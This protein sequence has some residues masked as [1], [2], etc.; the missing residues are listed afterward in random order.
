MKHTLWPSLY[1]HLWL[2]AV[3]GCVAHKPVRVVV[4]LQVQEA[5]EFVLAVADKMPL[6]DADVTIAQYER[7]E[8]A[9]VKADIEVAK[10]A[11]S[12]I[13]LLRDVSKL[14]ADWKAL[15]ALDELLRHTSLT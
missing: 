12:E 10:L 8:I 1:I 13:E 15:C 9:N 14:R 7:V 5:K 11:T 3:V 6:W 2:L 4:N